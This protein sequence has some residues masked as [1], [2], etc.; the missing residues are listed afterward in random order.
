MDST[1]TGV[2][3][4]LLLRPLAAIMLGGSAAFLL[5]DVFLNP[6]AI[7]AFRIATIVV[8]GAVTIVLFV[9]AEL[10]LSRLRALEIVLFVA[11]AVHILVLD[12][13]LLIQEAAGGNA[14]LVLSR[15]NLTSVPSCC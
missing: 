1:V 10:A 9:A 2:I 14:G 3:L 4:R 5:R 6:A 15:W 7:G 12:H 11:M 8:I 13:G